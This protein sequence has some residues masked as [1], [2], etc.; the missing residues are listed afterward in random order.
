MKEKQDKLK[1]GIVPKIVLY[2]DEVPYHDIYS[3]V[4][5]YIKRVDEADAIPIGLVL[6][7]GNI[8]KE[9]LDLCDAFIIPGGTKIEHAL[10]QILEYAYEHHKPVL[11]ICMGMQVMSIYSVLHDK[12]VNAF[13]REGFK[14][15]YYEVKDDNPVLNLLEDNSMHAHYITRDNINETKHEI[16]IDKDSFLHDVY[17]QDKRNVVSLHSAYINRVG[18]ILNITAHASDGLIEGVENIDLLW[19]GVQYHPEI[20]EDDKLIYKF[21]KEIEGRK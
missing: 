21:I 9:Q 13:D 19:I 4:N 15:T 12:G 2:T 7:D 14:K 6:N 8:I 10:Y 18:S 1:I 5:M 17:N 11:G 16:T 3:Y 20:D